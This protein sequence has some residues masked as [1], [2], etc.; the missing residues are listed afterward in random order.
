MGPSELSFATIRARRFGRVTPALPDHFVGYMSK[1][2]FAVFFA[3]RPLDGD[4][5]AWMQYKL[6]SAGMEVQSIG[7][8]D[9]HTEADGSW[10]SMP[11]R[12]RHIDIADFERGA[13]LLTF[14]PESFEAAM[15]LPAVED[16]GLPPPLSAFVAACELLTG[17]DFI[18]LLSSEPL[19]ADRL[20]KYV[21][22]LAAEIADGPSARLCERDCTAIFLSNFHIVILEDEQPLLTELSS[23]NVAGGTAYFPHLLQLHE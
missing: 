19:E 18:A 6:G 23:V 16:F 11:C 22:D 12:A 15:K 3:G 21:V 4:H 7:I 2:H 17:G 5:L 9:G 14:A 20:S 10:G 1:Q 13:L 8:V